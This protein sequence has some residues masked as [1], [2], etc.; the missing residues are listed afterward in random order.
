[1]TKAKLSILTAMG[2]FG[3][4]GIFVRFIPLPSATIAFCRGVMGFAFLLLFMCLTGKKLSRTDIRQNFWILLLSGGAI[5]ANWILLFEAYRYTT[6]AVATVCY[7]LAP[8]FVLLAS[9]LL[10]ERLTVKKTACIVLALIGMVFVSGVLRD[11]FSGIMGVLLGI[12]AAILYASVMLMNKKMRP[13]SAYDKTALQ[14]GSAA[15]VVLPYLLL[16]GGFSFTQM[17]PVSWILLVVVGIVHTGIA[18]T[19][20]FG[21]IKNLSAQSVAILSYLDPVLSI[22]LSALILREHMDVYGIVGAVLIL[23]SALYSELPDRKHKKPEVKT[24]EK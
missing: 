17:Q 12:G 14:L 1:M 24:I 11:G 5:G 23:G 3:T 19:L 6:V 22:I 20:Y 4:V 15:V 16:T 21:S 7:Y 8:V 18:Y 9:P 13:I 10:G 2:I